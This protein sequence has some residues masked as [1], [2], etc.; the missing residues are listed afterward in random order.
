M[1]E[2][3]LLG[4][5]AFVLGAIPF[6]YL[7]GRMRG[8]DIRQHGSGNIG[9]TNTLRVLGV[10]PGI[11]VLLL[12]VLKGYV[13]V[14]LAHRLDL[15]HW[16]TTAVGLLAILGHTFSPFLGFRGG[17][18]I[19][20]SLGVLLGLSA[21]VA[22]ASLLAFLV[23]VLLTRY[24]SLGSILAAIAQAALFWA[25]EHPLAYR[26]LGLFAALFVLFKHQGNI[27][28][29]RNGTESKIG[30]KKSPSG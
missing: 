21:P 18:G 28:R 15:G 20:T 26:L 12:D 27:E 2:T 8:I 13:P 9:A 1:T 25:W 7:A 5:G 6:G 10:V 29:L 4:I 23:V 19:A 3:L 24:V 11:L 17:K 22:G 14:L 16:E 30:A